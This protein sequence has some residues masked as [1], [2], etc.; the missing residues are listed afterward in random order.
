MTVLNEH[1]RPAQTRRPVGIGVA[2]SCR[3]L[4][5]L[6]GARRDERAGWGVEKVRSLDD[7]ENVCGKTMNGSKVFAQTSIEVLGPHV[8]V[9]LFVLLPFAQDLPNTSQI[10]L[11]PA[12]IPIQLEHK[13]RS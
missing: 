5:R 3:T 6:P 2:D 7:G 10:H 11:L 9:V 1:P 12:F 8:A 4:E 13:T